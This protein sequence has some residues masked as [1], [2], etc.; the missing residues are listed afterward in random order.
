[1]NCTIS[2]CNAEIARLVAD[3]A[4]EAVIAGARERRA[5]AERKEERRALVVLI[6]RLD[7]CRENRRGARLSTDE[8]RLLLDE[9]YLLKGQAIIG[10]R[11]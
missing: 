2:E 10:A 6:D 9:V 8:V 5:V 3:K 7:A 11:Q 1:M 4:D